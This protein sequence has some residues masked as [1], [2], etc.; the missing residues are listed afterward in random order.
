MNAWDS[1]IWPVDW[2]NFSADDSCSYEGFKYMYFM[3]WFQC[4]DMLI[5]LYL[6]VCRYVNF[7][8]SL[9]YL[10][11]NFSNLQAIFYHKAHSSSSSSFGRQK[12]GNHKIFPQP[13]V[14]HQCSNLTCFE[15]PSLP[16]KSVNIGASKGLISG[17]SALDGDDSVLL[18]VVYERRFCC[19]LLV[20]L[21]TPLQPTKF[22]KSA[23]F[24]SHMPD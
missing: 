20:V 23:S 16:L 19:W 8:I 15:S 1:C 13:L 7:I 18:V 2:N 3:Y 22:N 4:V 17:Y 24:L 5:L 9:S 14:S 6:W 11:C 21:G 10:H 12:A